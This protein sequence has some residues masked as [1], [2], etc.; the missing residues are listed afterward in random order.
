MVIRENRRF[1]I[2]GA[3][4]LFFPEKR[5]NATGT[6]A[7]VTFGSQQAIFTIRKNARPE[8]IVEPL[9]GSEG[10]SAKTG[11]QAFEILR[12]P[13]VFL[14]LTQTPVM[15][16]HELI[17]S[18]RYTERDSAPFSLETALADS[19]I[20]DGANGSLKMDSL[21]AVMPE[22]RARERLDNPI[23]GHTGPKSVTVV[24]AALKALV[25]CAERLKSPEPSLYIHICGEGFGAYAFSGGK[26]VFMRETPIPLTADNSWLHRTA[27]EEIARSADFLSRTSG[28]QL[29]SAWLLGPGSADG[30]QGSLS[31]ALGMEV[32]EYDPSLDFSITFTGSRHFQPGS[33]AVMIGAALDMGETI[34]LA[35]Q[36]AVKRGRLKRPVTAAAMLGMVAL[37]CAVIGWGFILKSMDDRIASLEKDISGAKKSAAIF[38]KTADALAAAQTENFAIRSRIKS[39]ETVTAEPRPAMSETLAILSANSPENV[40]LTSFRVNIPVHDRQDAGLPAAN[41]TAPRNTRIEGLARGTEAEMMAG[42]SSLISTLSGSPLFS[43]VTLSKLRKEPQGSPISGMT[44]FEIVADFNL[45]GRNG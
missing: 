1:S 13:N 9:N 42:V 35:P 27:P 23:H 41:S 6:R 3:N 19:W 44:S 29:E 28:I 40:A 17:S 31:S 7:L 10:A 5:P 14:K 4:S 8:I 15:P 16:K 34:K 2:L 21:I 20:M 37:V 26:L 33:L 39:L 38:E 12:S 22:D 25:T 43:S 11:I 32:K 36:K 24:P 45:P 30:L 18:I